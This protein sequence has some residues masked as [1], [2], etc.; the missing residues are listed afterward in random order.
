MYSVW[1]KYAVN[2]VSQK[3]GIITV[4][5]FWRKQGT[6][7][8]R[9]EIAQPQYHPGLSRTWGA[10]S[11]RGPWQ[12][13]L[14]DDVMRTWQLGLTG[15]R[16]MLLY[17]RP[18]RDSQPRTSTS[19]FT[20]T[21]PEFW[22]TAFS[23][24]APLLHW[25]YA[26]ALLS[27]AWELDTVTRYESL[28]SWAETDW[29]YWLRTRSKQIGWKVQK[30]ADPK[31]DMRILGV[32]PSS[33]SSYKT[34]LKQKLNGEKRSEKWD[35][36]LSHFRSVLGWAMLFSCPVDWLD[37]GNNMAQPKNNNNKTNNNNR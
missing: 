5:C 32:I 33:L 37:H 16:S 14:A 26:A 15:V 17:R 19:T 35:G 10:A 31:H 23:N 18:Q 21:A 34:T 30:N 11:G 24:L 13:Q 22:R 4:M 9:P 25:L 8:T 1:R 3:A 6:I 27:A 20:D 28:R 2:C 12:P 36:E 29:H 7:M